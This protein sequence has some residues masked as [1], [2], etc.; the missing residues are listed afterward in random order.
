MIELITGLPGFGKTL[1]MTRWAY[2]A[3]KKGKKVYANYPLEGAELVD[4][5][6]G[7]LGN[8]QNALICVDEASVVF[9][10][11]FMS[12]VPKRVWTELKQHRHDGVDLL[13]TSQ[14]I[15]DLAYPVRRLIQFHW[16]V[17]FKCYRFVFV[18]CRVPRK[19]GDNY[20]KRIWYISPKI[21]QLYDTHHKVEVDSLTTRQIEEVKKRD[22]YFDMQDNYLDSTFKHIIN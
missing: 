4:D 21:Y 3:M 7:L 11:L 9:D 16:D 8:V 15:G 1:T 12:K 22:R 5:I 13:L 14:D 18:T 19:R 10:Q 2:K 6:F 17:Y 20:G